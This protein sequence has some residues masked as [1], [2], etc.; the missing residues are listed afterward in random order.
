ML[1]HG[2][3]GTGKTLFA[4]KLARASGLDYAILTGGDVAPLGR[5]AVTEIHR[6]FDWAATSRRGLL[7]FIDEADAFL[8]SRREATS[9][10]LRNAFNAFLYRMASRAATSCSSTPRTRPR[11]ST[12][13]STTASTRWS[14]SRCPAGPSARMLR[15]YLDEYFGAGDVADAKLDGAVAATE[16]FSGREIKPVVA[17][18]AAASARRGRRARRRD[19]RRGPR[20]ARGAARRPS[21]WNALAAA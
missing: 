14:A 21:G 11:T 10:D 7:L 18:K 1:L 17:W 5:D 16:G 2:P 9:E 13:R 12:G 3:P 4:K 19:A 20:R 6:L 8:R 15:Q